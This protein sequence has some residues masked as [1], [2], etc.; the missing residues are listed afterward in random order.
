MIYELPSSFAAIRL[1][2]EA[3]VARNESPF[4]LSSQVYDYGGQRHRAAITLPD[5]SAAEGKPW[6]V[7]FRRLNGPVGTFYICPVTEANP[8]GGSLDGS[9]VISG[10]GQTGETINVTGF[11]ANFYKVLVAGDWVSIAD[12]LYM[13]LDDVSADGAGAAELKLWPK[14]ATAPS[15]AAPVEIRAPRGVFRLPG[16][17]PS[18]ELN[19]GRRY[20]GVQF[21]A[22]E[23][24]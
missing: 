14:V 18:M 2:S 15:D 19:Q 12:R 5:L 21:E 22:I 16:D 4:A 8:Q 3:A 17:A 10:A 24:I 7:F 1:T 13:V 23:A 20:S 11:T 6:L 9:P